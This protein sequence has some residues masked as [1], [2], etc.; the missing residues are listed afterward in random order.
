MTCAIFGGFSGVWSIKFK[1]MTTD[2]Q[3]QDVIRWGLNLLDFGPLFNNT[4]GNEYNSEDGSIYHGQY[5]REYN[6][7]TSCNSGCN[8]VEND[9]IIAHTLQEEFSR[10]EVDNGAQSSHAEQEQ[11]HSSNISSDWLV[12]S[13]TNYCTGIIFYYLVTLSFILLSFSCAYL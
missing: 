9:A 1:K 8:Y 7:D 6:Y 13:S 5:M 12:P 2:E 3:D 10:L 11:F 4:Y